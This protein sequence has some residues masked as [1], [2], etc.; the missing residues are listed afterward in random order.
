MKT[1][2]LFLCVFVLSAEAQD[3][4]MPYYR[5][6]DIHIEGEDTTRSE[7][8]IGAIVSLWREYKA[9]CWADSSLVDGAI[10]PVW[11]DDKVEEVWIMGHRHNAGVSD[12]C[13]PEKRWVHP[14]PSTEEFL[15]VWLPKKLVSTP[16]SE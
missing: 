5:N 11:D 1:L 4:M 10:V 15:D 2:I 12:G 3:E 16:R 6:K 14:K 7:M 9:Q 8:I 13:R